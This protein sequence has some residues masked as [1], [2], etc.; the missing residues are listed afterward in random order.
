MID[1]NAFISALKT[2]WIRRIIT[3]N[4][5]WLDIVSKLIDID[6]LLNCDSH[7]PETI[8]KS[9]KNLFWKDT[10]NAFVQLCKIKYPMF[11]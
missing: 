1:L 7:Y 6:K 10:L 4:G 11:R 3:S 5:K 8:A 9:C 2:T